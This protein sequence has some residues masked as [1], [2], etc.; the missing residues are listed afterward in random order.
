MG[1]VSIGRI[2]KISIGCRV[3]LRKSCHICVKSLRKKL[4][5]FVSLSALL[6]CNATTRRCSS[7]SLMLVFTI[8]L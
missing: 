6:A 7:L 1:I 8:D 4:A 2:S 3:G 5:M